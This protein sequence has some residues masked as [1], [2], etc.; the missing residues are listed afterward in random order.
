MYHIDIKNKIRLQ[1]WKHNQ[2]NKLHVIFCCAIIIHLMLP[3]CI[4]AHDDEDFLLM[5]LSGDA[6]LISIATGSLQP[7]SKAPAVASV[8]T[9][10]EIKASGA[11]TIQ[12]VL[13]LIPG[14]HIGVSSMNRMRP[15]FSLRG[16]HTANS[17][18]VLILMNGIAILDLF[19]GNIL[20][21]IHLPVTN[22]ARI[23]VIRG[24]GSAIYGA[25]AFAGVINIITKISEDINGIEV[26]VRVGSF[27]TKN[28][29][30]LYGGQLTQWNVA[31]SSEYSKSDGDQGRIIDSDLQTILDNKYDTTASLSP[32]PLDTRYESIVNNLHI[33]N[34]RWAFNVQSWHQY[35]T[36]VGAGSAQA[37]DHQGKGDIEQYLLVFDHQSLSS[38]AGW[39]FNSRFSFFYNDFNAK[40]YA[41]P[42]GARLPIG[43]DGNVDFMSQ[44]IVDFPDGFIGNPSSIK[45]VTSL[46]LIS[47]YSGWKNHHWRV[48]IG[49][50][51]QAL[52]SKETKNF[53]PGVITPNQ[54]V[55]SGDLSDVTGTDFIYIKDTRRRNQFV[56]VQDEWHMVRDWLLTAGV[57]YDNYSDFGSTINPRLSLVWETWHDLTSKLLYGHGFRAPAFAELR[58]I[59]NPILLG[60]PDLKPETIR[61]LELVFDYRPI[62]NFKFIFNLFRYEIKDLIEY[63]DDDGEPGGS[64]TAQ[65]NKNQQA[66]GVEFEADW[67]LTRQFRL[68]GNFSLQNA[69][70][71]DSNE[72]VPDA[73]NKQ[74]YIAANW[75]LA[76]KWFVRLDGFRVM[77]RKRLAG[78]R[79]DAVKDYNWINL[80]VRAEQ[81][82]EYGSLTLGVR[83]LMD[84]EAHEPAGRS[85]PNDYPL[86]SRSIYLAA[87]L[88]Y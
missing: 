45:K 88:E 76:N 2:K 9:A 87:S 32:G 64:S 54:S 58:A 33:A 36:G 34:D 70:D 21:N 8:I 7:I 14:L 73:P 24:P 13:E 31:L 41:F 19:N 39:K 4:Y 65:N 63:V 48:G 77:D 42:P 75:Q 66:L 40:F 67:Q 52:N 50:K 15:V 61:T 22:I 71:S 53:G 37:L 29:W 27:N 28:V 78:D 16:N 11:T 62:S 5:E 20:P 49:S 47:Y 3:D 55:V 80:T 17:A 84:S 82:F 56:S 1:Q 18:Q 86:P 85:I 46:E 83:N 35:D 43:N 23:E 10:K 51:W 60:N 68:T 26:G 12:E 69:K 44:R 74:L 38:S 72:S 79:R 6:D 25:D 30:A 57:R 59:N 81:I